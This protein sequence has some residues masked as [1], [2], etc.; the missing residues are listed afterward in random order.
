[1]P[2]SIYGFGLLF[3]ANLASI[4]LY[5]RFRTGGGGGNFTGIPG[6]SDT[7]FIF[8]RIYANPF[9]TVVFQSHG[10]IV[11]QIIYTGISIVAVFQYSILYFYAM[12]RC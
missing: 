10:F 8:C 4:G 12:V 7:T 5:A 2:Q 1:M 3:T 6:M 11:T 9:A